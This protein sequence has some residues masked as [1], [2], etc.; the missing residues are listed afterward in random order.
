MAIA[1]AV[2]DSKD[3]GLKAAMPDTRIC[4]YVC[5]HIFVCVC[6]HTYAV[7]DSK[8]SGL[9]AAMPDTR[10]CMYVRMYVYIYLCVYVYVCNV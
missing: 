7:I 9:K 6:M 8:D 5:I 3:S 10:I 1:F 4:M 2:I